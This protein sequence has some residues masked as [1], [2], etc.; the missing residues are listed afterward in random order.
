MTTKEA[1]QAM[2]DGKKVRPNR[3]DVCEFEYYYFKDNCFYDHN[4]LFDDV[5]RWFEEYDNW[6]IYEEPKQK[7]VV[8]IEKWLIFDKLTKSYSIAEE[9]NIE[10]F[11]KDDRD[12][13]SKVKLINTYTY[14]V[15]L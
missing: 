8:V 7:Q 12:Y 13:L 1:I 6:E 5:N 11:L 2:L 4:G 14:E 9:S 3:G 15:E 10:E